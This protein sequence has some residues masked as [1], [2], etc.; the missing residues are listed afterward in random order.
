MISQRDAFFGE[1]YKLALKDKRIVIVSADWGAPSLNE[2]REKIP[3]QFINVGIAEQNMIAVA[4]GLALM[5][6]RPYCVA[7][8]PFAT[9]RCYEFIKVDVCL[10]NLPIVIVG[11]GAG[12]SY[13]EA[14]PTHH[15]TED[16]SIM[17]VLP[18]MAVACP[19]DSDIAAELAKVYDRP[20]YIRLDR[21]TEPSI[22]T[23]RYIIE[24]DVLIIAMGHMVH[25]AMRYNTA[26][27][28]VVWLKPFNL[29]TT[30]LNYK[31]LITLE[32]HQLAGGLGS[33]VTE[34]LSDNQIN[35]PLTRIGINNEYFY[36]YGEREDIWDGEIR[37]HQVLTEYRRKVTETKPDSK[38]S[39]VRVT[40]RPIYLPSGKE[41]T[42]A[43]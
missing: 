4:T 18:S 16:V 8:A 32:E 43:G 30:I 19:Y 10:M 20:T 35:I 17:R 36:K 40:S 41:Y 33:M 26:V 25:V 7:I 2:W 12:L 23:Q 39:S 11:C 15:A 21:Q 34:Y 24:K 37:L 42:G 9:L 31:L 27:M 29:P 3:D 5:G 6:K 14:G 22:H 28:P 13:N 1:L 38:E